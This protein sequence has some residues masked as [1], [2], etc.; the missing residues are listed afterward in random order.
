VFS[1]PLP[2]R[3]SPFWVLVYLKRCFHSS[4][5]LHPHIRRTCNALLQRSPISFLVFPVIL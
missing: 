3:Y 5:F 2:W 4:P 1:P